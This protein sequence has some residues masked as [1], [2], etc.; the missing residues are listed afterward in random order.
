MNRTILL[1]AA[2]CLIAF[3]SLYAVFTRAAGVEDRGERLPASPATGASLSP[4][5]EAAQVLGSLC[6]QYAQQWRMWE[7]SPHRLLSRALP[8]PLPE[9][10]IE[11]V[12]A[13]QRS[14][15]DSFL[16]AT[17][18]LHR[19]EETETLPCVVDP[20]AKQVRLFHQSTWLTGDE[21]LKTTPVTPT[22]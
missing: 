18:L 13:P 22:R 8:P 21:W 3:A 15:G 2:G 10:R 20:A 16:L 19:G 5:Q 4:Q 12:L 7:E 6:D 9:L 17:I 1:P 11:F 14:S